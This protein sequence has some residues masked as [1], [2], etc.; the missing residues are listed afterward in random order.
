MCHWSPLFHTPAPK[1]SLLTHRS[2]EISV[3]ICIKT[4]RCGLSCSRTGHIWQTVAHSVESHGMKFP[5]QSC[6][7]QKE[8]WKLTSCLQT[9]L[10]DSEHRSPIK[11]FPCYKTLIQECVL[12]YCCS[13]GSENIWMSQ[14]SWWQ[15]WHH[16]LFGCSASWS[17]WSKI[18]KM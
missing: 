10:K 18:L 2:D 15:K 13:G 7:C 17:I 4:W 12:K 5:G 6:I 14:S 3:S 9:Y 1:P 8:I 16:F 11:A